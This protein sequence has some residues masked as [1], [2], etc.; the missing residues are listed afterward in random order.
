MSG[1]PLVL[2]TLSGGCF[3]CTEAIFKSLKGVI[4]VMPGYAGGKVENPTYEQVCT[5][6]TGHAE[7]IQITFN[8]NLIPYQ[9]L[10]EIFFGTHNP[11]TLNRQGNDVGEQYRSVI[12]THSEE[13]NKVA[14]QV[15]SQL[16]KDKLFDKPIVTEIIPFTNFYPAENYHRNYFDKNPGQP[17]C[18]TIINPKLAK[19]REH[20]KDLMKSA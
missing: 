19:F 9:A 4:N 8:E 1:E 10:V 12:F 7:A 3:W 18:Q 20:Y 11:T 17:Y 2:A 15:K 5:G 14:N 6:T 13:Q 16:E